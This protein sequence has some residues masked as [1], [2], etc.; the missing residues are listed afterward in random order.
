MWNLRVVTLDDREHDFK[1]ADAQTALTVFGPYFQRIEAEAEVV[2]RPQGEY[3]GRNVGEIL[4]VYRFAYMEQ[5]GVINTLVIVVNPA[6][7]GD[8]RRHALILIKIRCGFDRKQ[9]QV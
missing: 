6:K 5:S 4:N 3:F 1:P 7:T 2:G 9:V 8:L